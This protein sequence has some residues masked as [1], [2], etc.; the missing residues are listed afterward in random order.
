MLI[1]LTF[2]IGR[3]RTSKC[4]LHNYITH[5]LHYILFL[6]HIFLIIAYDGSAK[7]SVFK[8]LNRVIRCT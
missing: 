7:E 6:A 5:M 3:T 2:F 8:R 4:H 1:V